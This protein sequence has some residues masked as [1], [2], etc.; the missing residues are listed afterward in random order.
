MSE[1]IKSD[2]SIIS[3]NFKKLFL[4]DP[5]GEQVLLSL[6]NEFY[7]RSSYDDNSNKMAFNEGQRSVLIFIYAQ[8]IKE[9]NPNV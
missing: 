9:E 5:T 3:G 2:L 8:L 7:A 1:V 4:N 6:D